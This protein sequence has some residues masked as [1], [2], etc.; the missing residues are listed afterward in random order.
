MI[1]INLLE[2]KEPIFQFK[3][4]HHKYKTNNDEKI[5]YSKKVISITK[6]SGLTVTILA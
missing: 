5:D 6:N 4:D 3:N 1:E 2:Q